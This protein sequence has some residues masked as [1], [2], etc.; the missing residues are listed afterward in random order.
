MPESQANPSSGRQ[1][2]AAHVWRKY[3]PILEGRRV[4][5]VGAGE[6]Y[7]R[8]YIQPPGTY[9]AVGFG[10]GCDAQIDLDAEPLPF[11][12][13]SW[14]TVLCLDVLEHLEHIHRMFD[15]LCRVSRRHVLLALPNPWTNFF[16][17]LRCPG[18]S[19]KGLM[20]FYGL[21]P[22]PPKD[23]H[24]WFFNA[25]EG[26]EFIK[27]RADRCGFRVSKME[28]E[29]VRGDNRL[30]R[31]ARAIFFRRDVDWTNLYSGPVWALLERK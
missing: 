21:P 22:E 1:K 15:E 7:L 25:D 5:D 29:Y 6:A 18:L 9:Y 27:Y 24:R 17:S 16:S 26:R 11:P 3:R 10:E 30:K 28:L 4:L 31:F 8:A 23:R 19:R 14:D 20:K 12:D 2:K 13:R